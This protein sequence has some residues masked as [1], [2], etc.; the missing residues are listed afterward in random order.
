MINAQG[1]NKTCCRQ[2]QQPDL[3]LIPIQNLIISQF[4]PDPDPTL[5]R[6]NPDPDPI[7]SDPD[8]ILIRYNPD[9]DPDPICSDPDPILIRPDWDLDPNPDTGWDPIL[10]HSDRDPLQS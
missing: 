10:I 5:I 7:R 9:P 6:Y 2:P 4:D 3:I 8:P 1:I